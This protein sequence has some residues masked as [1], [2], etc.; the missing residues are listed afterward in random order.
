M[1]AKHTET[2]QVISNTITGMSWSIV[3][4]QERHLDMDREVEQ[5]HTKE[6]QKLRSPTSR[7]KRGLLYYQIC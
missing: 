7:V 1:Q 2:I 4:E 6:R 3:C 5:N